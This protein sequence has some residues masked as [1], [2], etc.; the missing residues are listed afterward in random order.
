MLL[1]YEQ[2]GT[3][4]WRIERKRK[5]VKLPI[6]DELNANTMLETISAVLVKASDKIHTLTCKNSNTD[7]VLTSLIN[8][9]FDLKKLD[10]W[11]KIK[12]N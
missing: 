10:E 4:F 9:N 2:G 8:S 12:S 1:Y 3:G 11:D 7:E 6:M 5:W